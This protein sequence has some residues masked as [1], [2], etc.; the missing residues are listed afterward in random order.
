[1]FFTQQPLPFV[2][3]VLLGGIYVIIRQRSNISRL[4]A[5]TEPKLGSSQTQKTL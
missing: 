4:L 1:M 3:L 2:L 5:G